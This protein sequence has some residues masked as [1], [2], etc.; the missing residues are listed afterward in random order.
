VPYIKGW[1]ITMISM[2]LE[3]ITD[4]TLLAKGYQNRLVCNVPPGTTATRYA[5][6]GIYLF[7]AH[8]H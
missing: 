5:V 1:H 4:G 2:H 3:A 7:P 6:A 8:P